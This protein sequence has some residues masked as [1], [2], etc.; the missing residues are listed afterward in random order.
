MRLIA[1]VV[2]LTLLSSGTQAAD[3]NSVDAIIR[4]VYELVSGPAGP[5]DWDRFEDL[6][7]EGARMIPVRTSQGGTEPRVLTVEEYAR[8]AQSNFT[9]GGFYESEVA[10]R[11]ETFGSVAQAFSTF[12]SRHAPNEKPFA[13]GINCIQLVKV[14][15]QWKVMTILWDVERGSSQIPAKYLASPATESQ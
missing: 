6:F 5:R 1:M 2:A 9:K 14:K 3:S 15:K 8:L 4:A 13:R 11:V 12:E 7:A 10:R